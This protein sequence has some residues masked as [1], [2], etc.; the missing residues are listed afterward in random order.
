MTSDPR[1]DRRHLFRWLAELYQLL[2]VRRDPEAAGRFAIVNAVIGVLLIV[3]GLLMTLGD[4][5]GSTVERGVVPAIGLAL[6]LGTVSIS[7]RP[8]AAFSILTV[9]AF[10]LLVFSAAFTW[11]SLR[12]LVDM[13]SHSFRY[14]PTMFLL[15]WVL[16]F[17]G[18]A[19]FGPWP[20]RA[21]LLRRAGLFLGVLSEVAFAGLALFT[22]WR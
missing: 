22:L 4:L 20:R 18:L 8:T 2:A 21:T 14:V 13:S 5:N 16:G 6:I 7:R 1:S 10:L 12:W 11:R 15:P 17:R 9:Q 19:A 3:V